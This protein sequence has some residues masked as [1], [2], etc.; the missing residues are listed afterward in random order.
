MHCAAKSLSCLTALSDRLFVF[1]VNDAQRRPI[2]A[3][4][5]LE[6]DLLSVQIA[7]THPQSLAAVQ[8]CDKVTLGIQHQRWKKILLGAPLQLDFL[9]GVQLLRLK[10]R[11]KRACDVGFFP[12]IPYDA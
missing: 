8:K 7:D 2:A 9:W 6:R 4:N 10:S 5:I 11:A 3:L 12:Y 1:T